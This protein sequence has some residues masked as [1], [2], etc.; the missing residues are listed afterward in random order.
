[1]K[2]IF[3]YI[4]FFLVTSCVQKEIAINSCQLEGEQRNIAS[5]QCSELFSPEKTSTIDLVNQ[6]VL[7]AITFKLKVIKMLLPASLH[8]SFW[9]L[10][11]EISQN[12]NSKFVLNSD[13]IKLTQYINDQLGLRLYYK[14]NTL[15]NQFIISKIEYI[16]KGKETLLTD[17]PYDYDQ[18]SLKNDL[19]IKLQEAVQVQLPND[20]KVLDKIK[21]NLYKMLEIE[22][23]N[24]N[25]FTASELYELSQLGPERRALTYSSVLY[26][27]KLK[28]FFFDDL[29]EKSLFTPIK[30][31][32][33]SSVSFYAL[34][35]LN[36][37]GTDKLNIQTNAE[38]KTPTW[39]AP[40]LVKMAIRY[41]VKVQ[42]DILRLTQMISN[43]TLIKIKSD[44]QI[45]T[46]K[47]K[48]LKI[49]DVDYL[50]IDVN[51]KTKKTMLMISHQ[52]DNGNNDFYAVEINPV[53]FPN[54]ISYFAIQSTN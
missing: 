29:I 50:G 43:G 34:S 13:E 15:S 47:G 21:Y 32:L 45:V 16:Q 31:L 6:N 40:S 7:K 44:G 8:D 14:Y 3:L 35:N 41:P 51:A 18:Q 5:Q 30:T 20:I 17:E 11:K 23:K 10:V 38:V 49:D 36:V 2:I 25:L 12:N 46:N 54:L 39:V 53:V 42:T 22:L 33:I 1:M 28:K 52:L 26:G 48:I 27:R 4:L 9:H 19:I 24:L 37:L